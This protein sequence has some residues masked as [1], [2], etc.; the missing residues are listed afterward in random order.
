MSFFAPQTGIECDTQTLHSMS[1]TRRPPHNI[2][3]KGIRSVS[4][5]SARNANKYCVLYTDCCGVIRFRFFLTVLFFNENM[6]LAFCEMSGMELLHCL[7]AIGVVLIAVYSLQW[8][9]LIYF[10]LLWK[11]PVGSLEPTY[12][13]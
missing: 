12:S 5:I 3:T 7:T 6:E 11:R 10:N 9:F 13:L 2:H 8:R 4:P 1:P